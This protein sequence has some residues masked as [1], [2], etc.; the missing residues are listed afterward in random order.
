V[1]SLGGRSGARV[2]ALHRRLARAAAHGPGG[3]LFLSL[4]V[5]AGAGLG[6]VAFRYMIVGFTY[7]FTGHR[8]YSTLGHASNPQAR[9]LGVWFVVLAP[10]IG[11][12]I[13][14][15][16][17]ARFA[18]EARGHGVPEVMLAVRR[19]GGRMRPQAPPRGSRPRSTRRSPACSS[20]S[21]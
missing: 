13:Y 6:A 17:V 1:S 19:L 4:L 10:V 16:L 7:A 12:L 8:D 3:M 21:S 14:G 20:R 18:P 11:G 5:G 15:P 9:G 2:R